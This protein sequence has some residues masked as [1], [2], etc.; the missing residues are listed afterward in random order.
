[1][2]SLL[3]NLRTLKYGWC[4]RPVSAK[5]GGVQGDLHLGTRGEGIAW[6][7]LPETALG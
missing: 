7:L 3:R 1:M 4:K 5:E 2:K 6:F